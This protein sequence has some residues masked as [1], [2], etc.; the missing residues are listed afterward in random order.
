[1]KSNKLRYNTLKI[2]SVFTFLALLGLL[3]P[4][5]SMA[6]SQW[7]KKLDMSCNS[8]HTVFPRLNNYGEQ[9]KLNG[10]QVETSEEDE[11]EDEFS[12]EDL[13]D[14]FG[15]R[16]NMDVFRVTTNNFVNNSGD[17]PTT[18]IEFGRPNWLQMF[19]AGSI[20]KNISFFSELEFK[21]KDFHFSWFYFNFTNL[22]D[23]KLLNLN[24][25]NLSP[26]DYSSFSNR[27]R[28][29]PNVKGQVQRIRTSGNSGEKSTDLSSSRPGI[30]YYGY[31]DWFVVYGGVTN[32]KIKTKSDQLDYWGGLRLL[33]PDNVIDGWEGSSV[34]MHYYAGTDTKNI[35]SGEGDTETSERYKNEFT[36]LYPSVNLKYKDYFD[37]QVGYV[38]ATEG[39]RG[40]VE[41]P[42][43]DYKYSGVAAQIS[44][45]PNANWHFGVHYDS[46]KSDSDAPIDGAG[47][48]EYARVVP[49][50]AYTISEKYAFW[51]YYEKDITPEGK[52]LKDAFYLNIR[53]MF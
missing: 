29:F 28:Q 53:T 41:D 43:E 2:T 8:C 17:D 32:G 21:E 6:T 51:L 45:L 16:L 1:M 31:G 20:Y 11:D 18:T 52:D 25:G 37:L 13:S 7:S 38:V 36:K 48:F 23:S 4:T 5:D 15:V 12:M 34:T 3:I 30:Q 50:I 33:L 47:D 22:F 39:N 42:T 35:T 19:A 46:Y 44:Y 10:Y 40:M 27:L 9:F 26:V 49:S 14:V 24:I